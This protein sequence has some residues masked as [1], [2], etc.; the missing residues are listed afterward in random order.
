[1]DI[2]L[3]VVAVLYFIFLSVWPELEPWLIQEM[4]FLIEKIEE[5]RHREW[6][7]SL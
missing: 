6:L 1:M 5:R 4:E 3:I 7:D 2:A